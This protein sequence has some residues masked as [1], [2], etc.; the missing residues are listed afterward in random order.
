MK[1]FLAVAFLS[2]LAIPA[3]SQDPPKLQLTCDASASLL[4]LRVNV[5]AIAPRQ[6]VESE[7]IDISSLVVFEPGDGHQNVRRTGTR[8][9]SRICGS[10]LVRISA[11][12]YNANP[13]GERGA[14]DDYPLIEVESGGRL[15]LGPVALGVC[16]AGSA[17][18]D[19]F[20][21]CPEEWATEVRIRA[22]SEG[23]HDVELQ[24]VYGERRFM[25][26]N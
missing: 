4:D 14:A 23:G 16:E 25:P 13:Q 5:P 8:T 2:L 6:N 7:E 24:H 10:L 26:P 12:Y 21:K 22:R 18:Q 3:R 1:H 9:E 20:A 17:R 15:L 11:G 19:A